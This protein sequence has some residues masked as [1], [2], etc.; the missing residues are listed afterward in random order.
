LRAYLNYIRTEYT[1]RRIT[2]DNQRLLA[3]KT[4]RNI[5]INLSGFF[6][7]ASLE[8][9][10]PNPMKGVLPPKFV[11]PQVEPLTKSDIEALLKA[12][13]YSAEA[14]TDF[15]RKFRMHRPTA[16][17][18]RAIILTLLDT[19]LRATELC[20]LLIKDV[21]LKTGPVEVRHGVGSGA[22]GG[23]GRVVFLG[24]T[25]RRTLWQYLAEREDG[26]DLEAP[27]FLGLVNRPMNK[28]SLRLVVKALA[29]KA[30]VWKCYP[31]RFRHTFGRPF[32]RLVNA[33]QGATRHQGRVFSPW[34]SGVSSCAGPVSFQGT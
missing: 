11:E 26:E 33:P 32:G 29:E 28:D 18:D 30:G 5:W 3:S 6:T 24:K 1:P 25:T 2:G 34:R 20:S 27:L 7:W 19:G 22:K 13:D 4:L 16:R 17:R 9:E 8:F 31:H 23:K 21:D 10:I 12:C 14:Q 15:R